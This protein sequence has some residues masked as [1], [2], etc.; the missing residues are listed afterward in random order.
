M[1]SSYY[2]SLSCP[3]GR[4]KA[5]GVSGRTT[6][7]IL[8]LV[9]RVRWV[10]AS[11]CNTNIS[12]PSYIHN[13]Y[14]NPTHMILHYGYGESAFLVDICKH[15]VVAKVSGSASTN[16]RPR[17]LKQHDYH[18]LSIPPFLPSTRLSPTP[19]RLSF[20]RTYS[21]FVGEHPLDFSPFRFPNV[22]DT[23]RSDV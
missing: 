6:S 20:F 22:S 4:V 19:Y 10:N 18:V 14:S 12:F 13:S 9:G 8:L 1:L 16:L 5:S 11:Q 3:R 2:P 23:C 7:F 15:L 17:T 21:P